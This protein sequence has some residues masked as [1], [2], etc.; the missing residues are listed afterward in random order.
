MRRS[1]EPDT[2]K[3]GHQTLTRSSVNTEQFGVPALAGGGAA[4][5]LALA[6]TENG[7][8][9]ALRQNLPR[10]QRNAAL[11]G[12]AEMKPNAASQHGPDA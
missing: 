12:V 6:P 2:L 11:R 3:R 5:R 8:S 7:R 1:C 10:G 4:G 9:D